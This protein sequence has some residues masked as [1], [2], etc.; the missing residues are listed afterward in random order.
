MKTSKKKKKKLSE[1]FNCLVVKFSVYLNKHVS[2][3][4]S[5]WALRLF[6]VVLFVSCPVHCLIAVFC[7]FYLAL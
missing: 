5:F 6:A 4:G 3:M 1:N 2:V 7:G